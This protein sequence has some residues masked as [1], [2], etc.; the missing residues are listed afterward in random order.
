MLKA[1]N[2]THKRHRPKRKERVIHGYFDTSDDQSDELDSQETYES[3]VDAYFEARLAD[4]ETVSNSFN[5]R[6]RTLPTSLKSEGERF[7]LS[8]RN[9]DEVLR[10]RDL[11]ET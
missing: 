3:Y 9:A 1:S 8:L 11:I 10:Y 2:S 7:N 5:K 4:P 6:P